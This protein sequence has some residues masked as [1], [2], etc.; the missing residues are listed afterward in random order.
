MA[1]IA[2]EPWDKKK[3]SERIGCLVFEFR[4]KMVVFAAG[5]LHGEADWRYL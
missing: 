2:A 5:N 1:A 4:I 3:R